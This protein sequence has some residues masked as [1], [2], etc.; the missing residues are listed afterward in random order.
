M[1]AN[2]TITATTA[3][4]AGQTTERPVF[5]PAADIYETPAGVLIRCDMPGVSEQDLEITLENKQ[6]TVTGPQMGQGREGFET[7]VGEYLTGIYQRSFALGRD[8]DDSA[9][10]ARLKDGVLEIELPKAREAQPR[11]ITV[12]AA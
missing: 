11:R 12:E 3:S 2:E 7:L 6:L 10:K 8:L 9:I 5:V 1:N 4:R